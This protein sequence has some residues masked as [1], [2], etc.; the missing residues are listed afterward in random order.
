MFPVSSPLVST[1]LVDIYA[2]CLH[3]YLGTYLKST[4]TFTS[5]LPGRAQPHY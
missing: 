1:I 5:W 2:G 3:T 4:P